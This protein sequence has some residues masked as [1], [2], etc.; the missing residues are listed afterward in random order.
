M[1]SAERRAACPASVAMAYDRV[2]ERYA[3]QFWNEFEQKHFDR[4]MLGWYAS[5]VPL[6]EVV[7]EVGS[8]PGEVSGYLAKLGVHCLGTDISSTMVACAKRLFPEAQ[9]AVEDYFA[10]SYENESFC[11]AVAYYAIVNHALSDLPPAFEEIYRVLKRSGLFLFTFHAYAGK[12]KTTIRDFFGTEVGEMPFYYYKIDAMKAVV[13][14]VGFQVVDIL[15]RQ[16]YVGF[17]YASR[18]AYFLLRKS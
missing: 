16:P 7:L 5:Q 17:E 11:A 2:A 9:F 12:E 3:E 4:I 13:E 14:S 15:E 8:G 10:L 1:S 18:R 6:G